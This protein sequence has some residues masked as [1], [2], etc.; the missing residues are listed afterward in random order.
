MSFL[1]C[2]CQWTAVE[3]AVTTLVLKQC[4]QLPWPKGSAIFGSIECLTNCQCGQRVQTAG[5]PREVIFISLSNSPALLRVPEI[6][7]KPLGLLEFCVWVGQWR[8]R[9]GW[10]GFCGLQTQSQA[11]DNQSSELHQGGLRGQ[12][13]SCYTIVGKHGGNCPPFSLLT[14]NWGQTLK[15]LS[16]IGNECSVPNPLCCK[17]NNVLGIWFIQTCFEGFYAGIS[18]IPGHRVLFITLEG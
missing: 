2:L 4:P 17:W 10:L 14:V 8:T 15:D 11:D 7:V 16:D 18:D 1:D 12:S 3:D 13:N 9:T 6:P 5:S